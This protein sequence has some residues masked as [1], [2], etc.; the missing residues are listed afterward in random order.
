MST[1]VGNLFPAKI[2]RQIANMPETTQVVIAQRVKAEKPAI[3]YEEAI[4]A[5]AECRSID[6]A[7][8][9]SDKA[10]ALA[11]YAKIF[12][13]KK[14]ATEAKRVKLHALR[15][16]GEIAEQLRPTVRGGGR[17][18]KGALSVLQDHGLTTHRAE[19][20]N[21]LCR[22]PR[23]AFE[24]AIAQPTPPSVKTLSRMGAGKGLQKA[25]TDAY[26]T[27]VGSGYAGAA[28]LAV[29]ARLFRRSDVK[30]M[31]RAVTLD[32]ATKIRALMLEIHEGLD[33]L[34]Q[35]MPSERRDDK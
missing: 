15:R 5:L 27:L 29:T 33:I 14:L 19:L 3:V 12:K 7:K 35:Y 23:T 31:A 1:T 18:H 32:E 10:D 30:E 8:Y 20:A 24:K 6:E 17:G 16:M 26:V 2:K 25:A 13:D 28:G 9:F 22:V 34:D 11:T 21:R 4:K